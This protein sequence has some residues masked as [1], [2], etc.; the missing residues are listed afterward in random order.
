M[1][2]AISFLFLLAFSMSSYAQDCDCKSAFDYVVQKVEANYSGF[3]DKVT[4]ATRPQYDQLTSEAR[5]LASKEVYQRQDSCFQL[6]SRWL[7]FMKDGHINISFTGSAPVVQDDPA[8]IRKRFA[9]WPSINHTE[10]SFA[11]YLAS[12]KKLKPLEG[13]W[14]MEGGQYKV[15]IIYT[16]DKYAAFILK[17]DSVYWMPGQIKFEVAPAKD[18]IRGTFYLRD[19]SQEAIAFDLAKANMGVLENNYRGSWYKLDKNG[20]FVDKSYYPGNK[21]VQFEKLSPET[22]LITIRSFSESY[23]NIIDSIV[24]ANDQ[25]I[26]K[27]KNLIIDVR[28]NGGGSDVSFYPLRKYLF[29]QP[30]LRYGAEM[31]CTDDNIQKFRELAT[32]TYF[33]AEERESFRKRVADMEKHLN[34]YWSPWPDT[35]MSDTLEV[36]AY[37]SN[38]AVVIDKRCASTTEQFLIDAVRNSKKAKIYGQASAGVLDY[39]NMFYFKVPNTPFQVNYATSR[40]KRIDYGLGIDNKGIQPDVALSSDQADWIRHIQAQLEKR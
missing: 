3:R 36:L 19:H 13:V 14:Q 6:L 17:A 39:A 15:G 38:I 9:G 33:S 24:K 7:K 11:K 20:R 34:Q 35:F 22:N 23:R 4:T 28:G 40:S 10:A 18:S 30:Y 2:K 26:S 5:T 1:Y 8:T 12:N 16:G 31:Y 21:M 32:D 37:P 25:L 27:T 29:T